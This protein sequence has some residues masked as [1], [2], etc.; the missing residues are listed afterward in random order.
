MNVL[1]NLITCQKIWRWLWESNQKE[2]TET[3]QIS[4]AY[5]LDYK[6]EF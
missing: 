4:K 6:E 2:N 1:R 5:V 3:Y